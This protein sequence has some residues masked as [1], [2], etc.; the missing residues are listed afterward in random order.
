M[1]SAIGGISTLGVRIVEGTDFTFSI[2]SYKRNI[3][4][5]DEIAKDQPM[6]SLDKAVWWIEYVIRHQG[7]KE[8]RYHGIDIPFYQYHFFDIIGVFIISLLLLVISFFYLL[9]LLRRNCSFSSTEEK[10]KLH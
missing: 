1:S 4:K 8:L 10:I 2:F 6:K 7:A 9:K 5:I 3:I